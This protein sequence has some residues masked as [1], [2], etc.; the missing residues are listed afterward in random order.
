M[1]PEDTIILGTIQKRTV[2]RLDEL[3]WDMKRASLEAVWGVKA[4]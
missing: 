1:T 3:G 2:Q 4:G